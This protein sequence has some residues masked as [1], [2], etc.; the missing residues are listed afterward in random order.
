MKTTIARS[1]EPILAKRK[2]KSSLEFKLYTS[3]YGAV[4]R[5]KSPI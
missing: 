2:T 5:R 4:F 1:Q 3:N